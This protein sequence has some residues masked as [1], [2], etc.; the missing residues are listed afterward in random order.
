V[1]QDQVHKI[2]RLIDDLELCHHKAQR[3]VDLIIEAIGAEEADK[4]YQGRESEKRHAATRVWQNAID[5][6]SAWLSDNT[7]TVNDLTVSD[8]PARE[9]IDSL[10]EA[11]PLKRWQVRQVVKKL[12]AASRMCPECQYS[13]IVEFPEQYND[14]I[15]FR[16]QTINTVIHD[17]VNG[18]P[19]EISLA[20][21][22][23]HLQPCNWNFPKNLVL[24]LRATNGDLEPTEPFAA[25]ARNAKLN[26]IRPRMLILVN[27]L[28]RFCGNDTG[29]SVIDEQVLGTL[30]DISPEKQSLA[31]SLSD[32]LQQMA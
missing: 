28:N 12:K 14:Q 30:G 20:G 6:L 1:E 17:T 5:I 29:N 27:T 15:E 31:R 25:H 32:K 22:I 19:A 13:E 8:M 2:K 16:D 11:T 24:V 3:H 10:G 18:E 7:S 23:D 4:G 26:P 9:L 21:A